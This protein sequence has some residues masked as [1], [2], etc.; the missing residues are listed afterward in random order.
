MRLVAAQRKRRISKVTQVL[1]WGLG[2][3]FY[4]LVSLLVKAAEEALPAA[5]RLDVPR[6]VFSEA[7]A[8]DHVNA[9]LKISSSN[10]SQVIGR[11]VGS[12]RAERDTVGYITQAL[13]AIVE[14]A[15][16]GGARVGMT[17]D[18]QRNVSGS[19]TRKEDAQRGAP[20]TMAYSGLTNI[21]LMLQRLNGTAHLDDDETACL[22][23][24]VHF[25]T[26]HFSPGA[27][28]SMNVA[29]LL[30]SVAPLALRNRINAPVILLF[31]DGG[32][33]GQLGVHGF[34]RQHRWARKV[35]AFITVDSWGGGGRLILMQV[36]DGAPW[37]AR[38][39]AKAP[40]PT[41]G[42]YASDLFRFGYTPLASSFEV[43]EDFV[44]ADGE[45]PRGVG[46]MYVAKHISYGILVMAY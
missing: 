44:P 8:M 36:S 7:R 46:L 17:L 11:V 10:E 12:P 5:K 30:E 28:N 21:V 43:L 27:S 35:R 40:M 3:G 22:L 29:N 6:A 1:Y 23:V 4:V 32:E 42:S 25:D 24:C 26:T 2:V 19:F 20:Y 31:S 13:E 39:Y 37:L 41:G 16:R 14:V 15:K 33:G 45:R 34:V 9:L 38:A 18:V